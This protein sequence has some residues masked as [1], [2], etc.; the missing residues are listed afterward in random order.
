VPYHL[1]ITSFNARA[2]P[3]AGASVDLAASHSFFRGHASTQ[4]VIIKT[5]GQLCDS[6]RSTARLPFLNS[7]RCRP[8]LAPSCRHSHPRQRQVYVLLA[9]YTALRGGSSICYAVPACSSSVQSRIHTRRAV[10]RRHQIYI[11]RGYA[12]EDSKD[13]ARGFCSLR[14]GLEQEDTSSPSSQLYVRVVSSVCPYFR[15]AHTP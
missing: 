11:S 7:A 4:T 15:G 12:W 3:T 2:L 8:A 6:A 10:A 13:R 5:T 9:D 1:Q 14:A